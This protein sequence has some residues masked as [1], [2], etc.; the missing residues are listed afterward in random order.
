M[1]YSET[2]RCHPTLSSARHARAGCRRGRQRHLDR[3]AGANGAS[4]PHYIPIAPDRDR[5]RGGQCR[6]GYTVQASADDLLATRLLAAHVGA[7]STFQPTRGGLSPVVLRR[8]IER[9][10]SDID[11][12]VSLAAL[13]SDAGLS[14][15]HF[16]RAFKESTGLSPHA[17][18]RQ[19]RL[20]EAKNMLR[21][22][23]ASVL[24]IAVALGYSSQTAFAAAFRKLTGDTPSNWRRRAR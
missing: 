24:S 4:R 3:S 5:R 6:R 16:C 12:D 8:A 7:P 2:C 15:F 13:A 19:Q 17:W 23:D 18:R 22:T 20:E 14:R 1:G 21:G 9:L 11:A 10:H